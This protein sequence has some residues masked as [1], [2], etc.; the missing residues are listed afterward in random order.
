MVMHIHDGSC[1]IPLPLHRG[2]LWPINLNPSDPRPVDPPVVVA[3][4][5]SGQ[6]WVGSIPLG[7]PS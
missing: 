7:K 2:R 4:D 3:K 6:L 5:S 1:P